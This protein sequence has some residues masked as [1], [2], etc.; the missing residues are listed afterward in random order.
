MRAETCQQI[1]AAFG[2]IFL[3]AIFLA[4]GVMKLFN[5]SGT[6][7]HM[8]QKGMTA[9]PLFLGLAIA[10]ELVGGLSVLLG[11]FTRYGAALLVLFLVPA[12]LVFHNFW[13]ET[14]MAAQSQMQHFM[15]NLAIMGG[16]LAVA[17]LGPGR[18]SL[19]HWWR[20]RAARASRPATQRR[21]EPMM[22]G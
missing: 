11:F 1:T 14:G 7:E 15:K 9:V 21:E 8:A 2:R 22:V 17:A 10:F 19:D 3:S 12:T 6:A 20:T 13:D 18:C 5:W 16:L 4:S